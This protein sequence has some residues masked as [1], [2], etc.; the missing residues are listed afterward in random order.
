VTRFLQA[1]S[2]CYVWVFSE[3]GYSLLYRAPNL[4]GN[5]R[6][7]QGSADCENVKVGIIET[8]IDLTSH[9]ARFLSVRLGC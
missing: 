5:R 9:A 1:Q 7:F 8:D 2:G 4:V 6:L 3:L